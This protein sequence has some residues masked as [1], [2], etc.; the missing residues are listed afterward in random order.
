MNFT[1]N[2]I[3]FENEIKRKDNL[4]I[5]YVPQTKVIRNGVN[6]FHGSSMLVGT[7]KEEKKVI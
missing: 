3:I 7:N 5:R 6:M 1:F 4:Q 2:E